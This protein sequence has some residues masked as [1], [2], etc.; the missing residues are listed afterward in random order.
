[1]VF[2]AVKSLEQ[3]HRFRQ[4]HPRY[5]F[6]IRGITN[7]SNLEKRL[8]SFF[9]KEHHNVKN[10]LRLNEFLLLTAG[11]VV[12]AV[13]INMFIAN[14]DFAFGGISGLSVIANALFAIPLGITYWVLNV[15]LFL[16]SIKIKGL[17]FAVRSIIATSEVSLF[18]FITETLQY[19][20]SDD[21]LA[22]VFGGIL[23]GVGVGLVICG[24]GS[25]GGTDM[26]AC[27]VKERWNFPLWVSIFIIDGAVSTTGAA[28]FGFNKALYSM[29]LVFFLA[30]S[31]EYVTQNFNK[32]RNNFLNIMA[33][34]HSMRHEH[35]SVYSHIV[36]ILHHATKWLF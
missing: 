17:P 11:S 4:Q 36:N 31:V 12:I 5:L 29:I 2:A 6:H 28:I 15:P 26:A 18:L 23:M 13:A 10:Y 25:S 20:P 34:R 16:L 24:G 7:A 14:H 22:A 1:V 33:E 8:D 3:P 35:N 21:I 32:L 27:I 9:D 30:R 19:V